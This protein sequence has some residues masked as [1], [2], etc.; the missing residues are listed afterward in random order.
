VQELEE[1]SVKA[2]LFFRPLRTSSTMKYATVEAYVHVKLY[3]KL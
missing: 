3:A 2:N 1:G